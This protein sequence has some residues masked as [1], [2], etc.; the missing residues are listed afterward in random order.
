MVHAAKIE[1]WGDR[2]PVTVTVGA[3]EAKP[4]DSVETM[5]ARAENAWQESLSQGGN[6]VVVRNG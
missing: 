2:L 3:T 5:V 1:W 4:G 6:R